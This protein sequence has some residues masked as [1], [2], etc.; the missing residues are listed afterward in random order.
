MGIRWEVVNF[1]GRDGEK[2]SSVNIPLPPGPWTLT[3]NSCSAKSGSH[4]LVSPTILSWSLFEAKT[5]KGEIFLAWLKN[6]TETA[7]SVDIYGSMS[8]EK[9]MRVAL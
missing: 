7:V 2:Q 9:F 8:S 6:I 5:S 1:L 4:L 3:L